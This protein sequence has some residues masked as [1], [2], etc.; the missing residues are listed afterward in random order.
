M[1]D[2]ASVVGEWNADNQ[3]SVFKYSAAGFEPSSTI[4][5]A[6]YHKSNINLGH[7]DRFVGL[8][9][10]KVVDLLKNSQYNV[11]HMHA[12]MLK[13]IQLDASFDLT[14][15]DGILVHATM[16]IVD[17][18]IRQRHQKKVDADVS[19]LLELKL[20]KYDEN[21][22]NQIQSELAKRSEGS[23]VYLRSI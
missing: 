13:I 17:F 14:D 9:K 3:I 6:L 12:F 10:G 16:K 23:Y 5:V 20:K 2:Q 18:R 8:H 11:R 7:F 15:K 1:Q 4:K 22:R 21:T 19:H